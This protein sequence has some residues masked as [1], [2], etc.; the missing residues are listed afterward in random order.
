M[1]ISRLPSGHSFIGITPPWRQEVNWHIFAEHH[2]EQKGLSRVKSV[3][4]QYLPVDHERASPAEVWLH[5]S[6]GQGAY[7]IRRV[8]NSRAR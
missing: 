7:T 4:S 1:N 5:N 2:V 6:G 8:N 3:R